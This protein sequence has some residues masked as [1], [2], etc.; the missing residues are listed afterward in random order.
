[1]K[2]LTGAITPNG[3]RV[4]IVAH[5][6]GLTLDVVPIDFTKGE[7][8]A[9]DYL[10]VNPMGKVPTLVDGDFVL[11]ESAAIL[12]HLAQTKGAQTKGGA[13]WPADPRAQADALRWLFFGACHLDPYFTTF[14]IERFIKPRRQLP[15]DDAALAYA[16]SFLVRFLPVLDEHL[17]SREHVAGAFGVADVAL[18]C[19]LELS[20]GVGFD[21]APYANVRAWLERVQ[22]RPSWRASTVAKKG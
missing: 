20:P 10:S 3:K 16:T 21:L 5:E 11:W 15:P 12:V 7:N 8:R 18:G 17:A 19:T 6:I 2:L 13:F 9:P 14:V 4:M 1:M 22:A